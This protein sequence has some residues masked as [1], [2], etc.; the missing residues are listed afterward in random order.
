MPKGLRDAVRAIRTA[1]IGSTVRK[2]R[3]EKLKPSAVVREIVRQVR[4]A[5][6]VKV[7]RLVRYNGLE[8]D[9]KRI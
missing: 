3:A 9:W 6:E 7:A 5:G 2:I 1:A 8:E 4:D